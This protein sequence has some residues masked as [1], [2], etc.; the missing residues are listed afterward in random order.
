[1]H[2]QPRAA[3]AVAL[4]AAAAAP[5]VAIA[6]DSA[7]P[8]LELPDSDIDTTWGLEEQRRTLQFGN[9]TL[10]GYGELHYNLVMPEGD[11]DNEST[12]DLHRLVLFVAHQF[13]QNLSFY[14]EIEVEHAIAGDGQPGEVA[15]EQAFIDYRLAGDALTLRAG[16]FLVPMGIVNIW[17][18]PPMFNGVE[19]PRTENVI[20]P[21]TWREAGLAF[22]GEPVDGFRYEL[23][24]ISGLDPMGFSA[25]SG[26]RGGRQKVGEAI[27]N[28]PA[29]YGR[30]EYE[31]VLGIVGSVAGYWSNAGRNIEGAD[32]DVPVTGISADARVRRSGFEG[33]V[34]FATFSVGNTD[35]LRAVT[36][37]TGAAIGPD[38][39]SRM[40][41][42]YVEAGYDVLHPI[43]SDHSLVPFVRYERYDT[44]AATDD[45]YG[46]TDRGATDLVF[47]ATYRP[48]PAVAFKTDVI[49]RNPDAED[50]DGAT[51]FDLGVGWMF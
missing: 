14:T 38:I 48:H 10:G 47:G 25:G 3:I 34:L 22:L 11:A 51:I 41:G 32:I 39:G 31:P 30:L 13:D 15:I 16:M 33:K 36:D 40:T 46:G 4:L 28:G 44:T 6:Q 29:L 42:G 1:M 8:E 19:R 17:H 26:I 24:V 12:I 5:S 27:T 45:E 43:D 49:L 18:E 35:E 2:A 9:T 7:G 20:I 50:A 37:D 23:G 21:T